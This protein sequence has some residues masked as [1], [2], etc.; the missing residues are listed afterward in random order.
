M[1]IL[2]R[3]PMMKS[4]TTNTMLNG[5]KEQKMSLPQLYPNFY[6]R[7]KKSVKV[8]DEVLVEY[9][10]YFEEGEEILSRCKEKK[11]NGCLGLVPNLVLLDDKVYITYEPC[12]MYF[13]RKVRDKLSGFIIEI[14]PEKNF[15]NF[16]IEKSHAEVINL[17][18]T[19]LQKELFRSGKGIFLYGPPGTGK[20]HLSYAILNEINQ[21]TDLFSFAVFV[22]EFIQ[23]IRDYFNQGDIE[24][25]PITEIAK[26][27]VLL[28]DDI[29]AERYTEWVQEQIVQLLDYRYRNNLSTIITSNLSLREIKEKFGDRI[30]SR[31]VGLCKP[32]LMLGKDKRKRQQNW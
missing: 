9:V 24:F 20:T 16:R 8:D 17:A 1:E 26:I 10:K 6:E 27:P 3:I 7:I 5:S 32:V 22:P 30:Y 19:F 18:N 31:M 11:C 21:K 15:N 4:M 2:K 23:K 14:P 28:V 13:Y 29:G 25:N 12:K